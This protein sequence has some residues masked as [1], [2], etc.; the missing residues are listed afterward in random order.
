MIELHKISAMKNYSTGEPNINLY[1][2]NLVPKKVEE[3]DLEYLF[4]RYFNSHSE[5][6]RLIL[7][8]HENLTIFRFFIDCLIFR[9]FFF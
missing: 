4:G 6:K 8:I 5:M 3:K 2:K 9:K 1:I 7:L